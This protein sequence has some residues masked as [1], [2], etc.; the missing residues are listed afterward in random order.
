M[1]CVERSSGVFYGVN[2]RIVTCHAWKP[3]MA[4]E[5]D[6]QFSDC[7]TVMLRYKIARTDLDKEWHRRLNNSVFV[8]ACGVVTEPEFLEV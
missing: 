7:S 2:I 4:S 3:N 5:L 6:R 8:E 1:W